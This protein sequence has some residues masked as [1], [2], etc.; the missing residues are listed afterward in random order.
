MPRLRGQI[1]HAKNGFGVFF[2]ITGKNVP[3]FGEFGI[4]GEHARVVDGRVDKHLDIII[5]QA[6]LH[7]GGGKI[8]GFRILAHL[9]EHIAD[10]SAGDKR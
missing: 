5:H 6:Q 4:L 1:R 2:R 10:D 8:I 3:R 9:Q 7:A